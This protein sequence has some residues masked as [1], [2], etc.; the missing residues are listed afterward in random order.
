MPDRKQFT[1][2]NG[3]RVAIYKPLRGLTKKDRDKHSQL[4]EAANRRQ[5][6]QQWQDEQ[7]KKKIDWLF[8]GILALVIIL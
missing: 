6:K 8:W 5:Q 4:V 1:V 3:D 2:K 7:P